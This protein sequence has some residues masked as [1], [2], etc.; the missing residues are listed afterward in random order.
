[1]AVLAGCAP[2][3]RDNGTLKDCRSTKT[4]DRGLVG[5]LVKIKTVFSMDATRNFCPKAKGR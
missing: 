1:M 2:I 3:P 5:N 4:S